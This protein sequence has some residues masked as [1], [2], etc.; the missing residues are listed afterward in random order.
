MGFHGFHLLLLAVFGVFLV[1]LVAHFSAGD[2]AA[3][4]PGVSL[5]HRPPDAVQQAC[6]KRAQIELVRVSAELLLGYHGKR[7]VLR[8]AQERAVKTHLHEVL[9]VKAAALDQGED[10]SRRGKGSGVF[11]RPVCKD[12]VLVPTD[13][14]AVI[15]TLFRCMVQGKG[16]FSNV[17]RVNVERLGGN[18]GHIR[19]GRHRGAAA[20]RSYAFGTDLHLEAVTVQGSAHVQGHFFQLPAAHGIGHLGAH[21]HLAVVDDALQVDARLPVLFQLERNL[22]GGG[23]KQHRQDIKDFFHQNLYVTVKVGMMGMR[24]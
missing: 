21:E 1:F 13:A 15:F 19:Q 9:Q 18:I 4:N 11:F 8:P 5:R 14:D 7:L 22:A 20:H 3:G 2:A 10:I 17:Q 6:V 23:K 12:Q 16:D 24:P